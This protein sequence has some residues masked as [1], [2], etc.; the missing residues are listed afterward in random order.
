MD[1]RL[2]RIARRFTDVAERWIPDAFVFALGATA[3]VFLSGLAI[4]TS[5]FELTRAWGDGFWELLSFTMQMALVIVIGYVVASAGPV[6][7]LVVWLAGRTPSPRGAVALVAAFAMLSSWLN[8]GFSLVFSAVLAREI[9]RRT[10]GVDY[11]ALSAASLLGLGSV[12]A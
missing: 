10:R 6:D 7:R 8:W 11:R 2:E 1:G 5:P 4:G 12:W 3:V 9:A